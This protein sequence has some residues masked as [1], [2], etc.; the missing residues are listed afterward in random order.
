MLLRTSTKFSSGID[1]CVVIISMPLQL[2]DVFQRGSVP[3]SRVKAH[4]A[5]IYGID[6]SHWLK[7][8]DVHGDEEGH[9][10]QE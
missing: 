8:R 3:L 4:D 7:S 9:R 5:K 10:K 2:I 1:E 6:W